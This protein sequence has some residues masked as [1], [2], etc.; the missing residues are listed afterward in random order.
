MPSGFS[1]SKALVFLHSSGSTFAITEIIRR[2]QPPPGAHTQELR[3]TN[4][5]IGHTVWF[6]ADTSLPS[7]DVTSSESGACFGTPCHW[8]MNYDPLWPNA[9]IRPS[10]PSNKSRI[11]LTHFNHLTGF[12]LS[13]NIFDRQSLQI[14]PPISRSSACL[15]TNVD[16]YGSIQRP[17]C[18]EV[19]ASFHQLVQ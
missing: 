19:T 1:Y 12:S 16:V 8:Q 17:V 13:C 11:F 18:A 14:S 9:F 5:V 10:Y 3:I 4:E 2:T 15:G 6:E 7:Q